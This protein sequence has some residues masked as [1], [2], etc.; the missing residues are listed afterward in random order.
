MSVL[1]VYDSFF[2]NTA[3]VAQAMGAALT[4]AGEQVTTQ[5]VGDVTPAHLPDLDLLV[6]GSPTRAFKPTKAIHRFL[7]QI[8]EQVL[9][10]TRV[11]AFD[12]RIS[13]T[14]VNSRLL[15]FLVKLFGY[16]AE[17]IAG[18]LQKKGG[19]L[20]LQPEGFIV[21]G[22]EGPLKQGE[23]KRAAAWAEAANKAV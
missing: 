8:P 10:G 6:V 4:A 23:L 9:K 22:T 11:A 3:E 7:K 1:I 18:K 13:L 20:V 19:R 14:D 2:G 21:K 17:P 15:N 12:T 5:G 16:A